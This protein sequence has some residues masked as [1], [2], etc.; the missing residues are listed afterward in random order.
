MIITLVSGGSG[1]INIQKGLY[2]INPEMSLNILINGYDDG[3]STGVLRKLFKNALGISDFRKNQLLEYKLING[4]NDIYKLLNH[5]FTSK[6]PYK[7]IINIINKL[8]IN[9][10]IKDFLVYNTEYFFKLEETKGIIYDDFNYMNIIYCSLLHKNK[11]DM[12]CVCNII[13]NIF[14]LKNNIY[15]NS[16]ENLILQGITKNKKILL[17]EA[18]I[19]DFN[20]NT[21]KIIDIKFNNSLPILD[22]KTEDL[23]LKSNIIILSCGTQFSSLIPTYKTLLFK[24]TFKKSKA[25]KYLVLNCE[26][27]ND[28][29]NYSGNELLDKINEYISLER[30]DVKIIISNDINKKLFPTKTNYNYINIPKLIINNIHN[31]F[32][33]WKYILKDY[34]NNYYNDNYIFDYDYTLFDAKMLSVSINNI[35]N[36]SKIKNK[37]IVTNNCISNLLPINNCVIYSNMSNIKSNESI[38]NNEYINN[39]YIL[40]DN[41]IAFI[42]NIITQLDIPDKYNIENRKYISVSIK[43]I[44]NRDKI[45]ENIKNL[46]IDTCYDVVKTGKTTIEFIKKGLCKRE[47]FINKKLLTNKHT[48][49]TDTNDINYNDNDTIKY[50]EVNNINMTNLF[51]NSLIMNNKYDICII[52][53]GINKRMKTNYPKC[54]I[55][56]ANVVVLT[57]ILN[58]VKPYANNIYVCCNNYYK[59]E[60]LIYEKNLNKNHYNNLFF[61]YFNSIDNSQNYPKGNGETIYQLLKTTNLTDKIFIMWSDILLTDNKIFEEMYN[62]QYNTDFL[63]P[64]IY[65]SNPY[66]YLIINDDNTVNKFEYKRNISIEY[67][68]HDQCIFLCNTYKIKEVLKILIKDSY[69]EINFLDVVSHIK[70]TSY[71]KTDYP[72]KS[73]NSFDDI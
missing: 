72:L 71:Y 48:Y 18:S 62:L 35:N 60:F 65:E 55:E 70:D 6:E 30:E 73:F 3:K 32:I 36:L 15:I 49:I 22:I 10:N 31:G 67:G 8:N 13:K 5:R 34:F 40:E 38:N 19:V 66:A 26:Y 9:N 50:L 59:K 58:K 24:E 21:D 57:E 29:I 43:P 27:D 47:L 28:I 11:A 2:K 51:I 41:D 44:I 68:Y 33:L 45:L 37:I 61:L 64:A 4:E 69:N 53:G 14:G 7:Y 39:N 46:L 63:I 23:L 56:I 16:N 25:K 42:E 52:A 20:D 17:D 1:S 54:L 12:V